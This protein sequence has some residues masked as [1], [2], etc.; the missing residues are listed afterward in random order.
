MCRKFTIRTKIVK[1]PSVSH[2]TI[3][4]NFDLHSLNLAPLRLTARVIVK[5]YTVKHVFF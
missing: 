1:K 4:L 5:T 2:Q 3:P